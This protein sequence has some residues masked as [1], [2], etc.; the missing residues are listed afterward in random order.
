MEEHVPAGLAAAAAKEKSFTPRILAR[1]KGIRRGN[2]RGQAVTEY[3]LVLILAFTFTHQVFFN[4]K[5]G[6]QSLLQSTML[7]IGSF[8]EQN[9]KSGTKVGGSDGQKSLDPFAG[10]DRWSN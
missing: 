5:F 2:Q 10:T 6:F 9:L 3:I 4:K 1:L 7:R 8:V